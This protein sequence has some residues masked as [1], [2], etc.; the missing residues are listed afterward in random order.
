MKE[1]LHEIGLGLL[2]IFGFAI[3]CTVLM[4]ILAAILWA[5]PV[6]AVIR[7]GREMEKVHQMAGYR[8][9]KAA[10]GQRLLVRARGPHVD[11]GKTTQDPPGVHPGSNLGGRVR[12]CRVARS[13]APRLARLLVWLCL[14][15]GSVHGPGPDHQPR[16]QTRSALRRDEARMRRRYKVSAL[17]T[18]ATPSQRAAT[19]WSSDPLAR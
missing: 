13:R 14:S 8:A 10:T 1:A 16:R 2:G 17:A 18:P 12:G 19:K 3:G 4:F 15:G 9:I 7:A 5:E 6:S 11:P